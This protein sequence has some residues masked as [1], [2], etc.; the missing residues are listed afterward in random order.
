[1]RRRWL[2]FWVAVVAAVVVDAATKA[3]ALASLEPGVP[4]R[5]LGGL[6]HLTLGFNRGIAFGLHLGPASRFVFTLLT[7]AVLAVALVLYAATPLERRAQ[8]LA[9]V[10]MCAGAVGNLVDR[11]LRARGVVDFIGPYDLGFMVWPIF[12]VA[13]CYVV[14][15]TLGFAAA[16]WLDRRVAKPH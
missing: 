5:S 13:D 3:W 9:L 8:R 16:V 6:L 7:I 1:L 2:T 14:L 10:L 15:G 12:N 4:E 11:V